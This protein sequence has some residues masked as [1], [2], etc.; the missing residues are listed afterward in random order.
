P[1]QY[2]I[3]NCLLTCCY[4][5]P[6][7]FIFNAPSPSQLYTLSLHDALPIYTPSLGQKPAFNRRVRHPIS[8]LTQ[9]NWIASR[10]RSRNRRQSTEDRTVG[11]DRWNSGDRH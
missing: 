8:R 1:Y 7:F 2:Y 11:S 9:S 3:Y 6:P 10:Y 5:P 4:P